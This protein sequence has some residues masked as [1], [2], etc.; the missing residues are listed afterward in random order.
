MPRRSARGHHDRCPL[1]PAAAHGVLQS[2]V[3]GFV[4]PTA[5]QNGHDLIR[6]PAM[7]VRMTVPGA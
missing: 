5:D 1:R 7:M 2:D 3:H 6:V 4:N